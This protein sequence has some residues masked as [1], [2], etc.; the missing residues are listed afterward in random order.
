[1][2]H[3]LEI[4]YSAEGECKTGFKKC[5]LTR[6]C[7]VWY[8]T[9]M[10][11]DKGAIFTVVGTSGKVSLAYKG[12]PNEREESSIVKL[13]EWSVNYQIDLCPVYLTF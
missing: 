9:G 12:R 8:E 7:N 2:V 1:M 11:I 10:H 5:V 4:Q 13:I 3:V 6:N